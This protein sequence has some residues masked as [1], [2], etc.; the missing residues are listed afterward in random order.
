MSITSPKTMRYT[1]LNSRPA[2]KPSFSVHRSVTKVEKGSLADET[3]GQV[4]HSVVKSAAIPAK[5]KIKL[6][7]YVDLFLRKI[8]ILHSRLQICHS[9]FIRFMKS[10]F[11]TIYISQFVF[12]ARMKRQKWKTSCISRRRILRRKIMQRKNKIALSARATSIA[13]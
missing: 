12:G 8:F 5:H 1:S 9:S 13:H 2:M 3:C 10:V 4:F 6:R 7:A 11:T